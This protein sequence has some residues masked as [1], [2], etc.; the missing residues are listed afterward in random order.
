VILIGITWLDART[1]TGEPTTDGLFHPAYTGALPTL[2]PA[3]LVLLAT[4]VVA[5][6]A[7]IVGLVAVFTSRRNAGSAGPGPAVALVTGAVA[8]P[9]SGAAVAVLWAGVA[10]IV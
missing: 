1:V 8:V 7:I 2:W 6:L 4:A 5:V 3:T 10:S 9:L